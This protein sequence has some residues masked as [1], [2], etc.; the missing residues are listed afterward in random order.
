[1]IYLT[2]KQCKKNPQKIEVSSWP[3]SRSSLN[4][5]DYAICGVLENKKKNATSHQ[6]IG[7]PKTTIYEEW[8]ALSEEFISKVCKTFR[9]R[10]DT[11][12]EKKMLTMLSKFT[13]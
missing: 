13:G 5:L 1:M 4:P 11:I 3:S 9:R 12:K 10:V 2:P 6:N 8:S 7:L